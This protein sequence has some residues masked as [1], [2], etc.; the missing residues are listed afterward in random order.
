MAS[1]IGERE[2]EEER[3]GGVFCRFRVLKSA[4]SSGGSG[5]W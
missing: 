4:R 5:T 3:G 2:W 1:L